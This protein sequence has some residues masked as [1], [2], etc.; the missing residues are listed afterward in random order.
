MFEFACGCF[1][2]FCLF[3]VLVN[4]VAC[5]CIFICKQLLL[6]VIGIAFVCLLRLMILCLFC[7]G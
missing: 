3:W 2:V 1:C 5:I 6:I 7:C 4:S